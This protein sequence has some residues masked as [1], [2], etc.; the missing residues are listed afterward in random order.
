MSAT[1]KRKV[2]RVAACHCALSLLVG[3]AAIFLPVIFR[4]GRHSAVEN[5]SQALSCVFYFLQPPYLLTFLRE[6]FAEDLLF[7]IPLWSLVF[8]WLY[9]K[10]TDRL[11]HFTVLGKKVF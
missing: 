7:S 1:Q 5:F 2:W 11:N 9:V 8:G 6:D 3:L 4:A 10:C